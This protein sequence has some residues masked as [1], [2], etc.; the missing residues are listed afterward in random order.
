MP[1]GGRF[2]GGIVGKRGSVKVTGILGRIVSSSVSAGPS[3]TRVEE[4][5]G[6]LIAA[7]AHQTDLLSRK[8]D[9]V[10]T[11][12]D[13]QSVLL[14][15]KLSQAVAGLD[16][17]SVLLNEKLNQVVVGLDNQS[18]LLNEKLNEV[19]R[20]IERIGHDQEFVDAA[21]QVLAANRAPPT[22]PHEPTLREALEQMPL[23]ID[24]RT[25]NTSHSGYDACVVRNF[26]GRIFNRDEPCENTVFEALGRLAHR[27]EV[28][29]QA[30]NSILAQALVEAASVPH[31]AQIFERR[32]YVEQYLRELERKYHAHYL[33]GWVNFDDALF[34]YWLVRQ[35]KPRTV[36]QTG[37]C[38]G[39][40]TAFMM[41]GL[42]KNGPE[43]RLHAI[44]L[45]PVFDAR[46][47][48]WTIEG[49]VY[50]F[51]VPEGKTS[52]WLLPEV[53]WERLDLR[54]GNARDLLPKM[55]DMLDSIDLFYHDSEH[56]Y[57]HMMYEFQQVKRKLNKCGLVVAD[58]VAWNASLWDFADEF[59]V[60]SY[61][62][63]GTVGVAF[64]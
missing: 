7:F 62:F 57:N 38:N 27:D 45:A 13:N 61:N 9:Q 63:K 29:D 64:F 54:A 25:Y 31:A 52:G 3:W 56:S 10:V 1:E 50:G 23:L 60:P 28:P 12:L 22:R 5:L 15:E 53:Y 46:D 19:V 51:V 8:F 11:G 4:Q 55:V 37:V 30:W 18:V 43:G 17:Q 48:S 42:A 47:P 40:S 44:D 33:P 32:S 34:L 35:L 24:E 16:N 6:T 41:L 2:R 39:L 21:Q 26:P 20:L 14:N 59:A 49:K 36:V 58:D